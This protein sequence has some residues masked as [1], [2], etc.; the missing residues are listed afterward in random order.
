[1]DHFKAAH[2]WLLDHHLPL[3]TVVGQIYLIQLLL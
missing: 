3:S 1:M 2:V